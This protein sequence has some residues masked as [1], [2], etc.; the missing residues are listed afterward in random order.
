MTYENFLKIT[1][2]LQK[3]GRDLNKL[4]E[5]NVDLIDFVDPYNE[6]IQVALS[7]IYTKEGLDWLSWFMYESDFG[8]KDWSKNAS[9]KRNNKG[10]IEIEHEV[11]E[12]RH[13]ATDENGEPIC[14]SFESTYEFLKQYRK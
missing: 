9:Y 6:I 10:N 7:E 14:Y 1:L 3:C 4:Y 8:Q 5:M 11:G 12:A 13:G 2:G